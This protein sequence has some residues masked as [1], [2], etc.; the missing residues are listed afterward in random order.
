M[1]LPD[2]IIVAM[3]RREM[4]LTRAKL[5]VL[6]Y[7]RSMGTHRLQSLVKKLRQVCGVTGQ[8]RSHCMT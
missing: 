7:E 5:H 1:V 6:N 8:R 3:L 4:L 2:S